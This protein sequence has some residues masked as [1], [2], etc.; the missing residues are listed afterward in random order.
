[1]K[2]KLEI[3]RGGKESREVGHKHA[4]RSRRRPHERRHNQQQHRP[5][6]I[7]LQTVI[8]GSDLVSSEEDEDETLRLAQS[9]R[10]RLACGVAPFGRGST[11]TTIR[12]DGNAGDSNVGEGRGWGGVGSDSPISSI[13]KMFGDI[14]GRGYA[15]SNGFLCFATPVRSASGEGGVADLD[16]DDL[17]AD[18]F[19][20]RHGN[21][22]GGGRRRIDSIDGGRGVD[23]EG[24]ATVDAPDSPTCCFPEEESANST[25]YFDQKY[26]H[27]VQTR[28][29]MPLFQENMLSCSDGR[30]DELSN[31][32]KR[33]PTVC[34]GGGASQPRTSNMRYEYELGRNS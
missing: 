9:F 33:R 23:G 28:P 19:M 32:L 14:Y 7:S 15:A 29:P 24:T 1:M 26:S 34:D 2:R 17:T 27:V 10:R 12:G 20:S 3:F 5:S 18:E 8:V 6:K 11:T 16:D 4:P 13:G 22:V 25:F 21:F 31:M 30:I